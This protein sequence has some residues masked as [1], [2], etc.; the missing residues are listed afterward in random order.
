MLQLGPEPMFLD[1]KH[2]S[3]ELPQFSVLNFLLSQHQDL[4]P[5]GENAEA[6]RSC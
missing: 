3:Y 5:T 4:F 6:R 2:N 1:Q